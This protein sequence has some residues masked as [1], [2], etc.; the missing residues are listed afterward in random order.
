ML[1]RCGDIVPSGQQVI[2]PDGHRG[3]EVVGDLAADLVDAA[4]DID[5]A[6]KAG[7][8]RSLSHEADHGVDAIEQ[9]ALAGARDVGKEA[10]LDRVVLRTVAWVV[11]HPD[12]DSDVVDEVL[13]I[14]FENV[15]RRRIAPAGIAQHQDG[16]GV[17]VALL[18]D[19]VPVPAETVARELA[20]VVAQP[21]VEVAAV[22]GNVVNAVRDDHAGGPT[23]EVVV[24]GLKCPLRPHAALAKELAE[25]LLGL[26]IDGEYGVSRS[27][28]LGFQFGD[29]LE[30]RVSIRAL[31][32]LQNLLDL[33]SRQLLRFHPVLNHR[34]TDGR[35]QLAHR[36]GDLAWR[37]VRPQDLGFV[38]VAGGAAFQNRFQVRLELRLGLDS[39]FRPPP[40]RLTRP[41][42]GS[43]G[44]R[45]SS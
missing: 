19:A 1:L 15:M 4:D 8:G 33:V 10:S 40:G 29:S 28:V 45:L 39:F 27:G 11:G 30:L 7:D 36:V 9:H 18:A 25:M 2:E 31:A 5:R 14:L 22:A 24:E 21:D 42:A 23:G 35:S 41:A 44:K 37:E 20:G 43:S 26:G 34:R 38:G 16:R 13:Q 6:A 17:G 12:G 3:F 32:T